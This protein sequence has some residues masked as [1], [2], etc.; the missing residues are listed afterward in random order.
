LAGVGFLQIGEALVCFF[1]VS[2]ADQILDRFL[3]GAGAILFFTGVPKD[4]L[5]RLE[6]EFEVVRELIICSCVDC[7]SHGMALAKKV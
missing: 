4:G 7:I 6:L 5:V 2:V 1:R 3:L